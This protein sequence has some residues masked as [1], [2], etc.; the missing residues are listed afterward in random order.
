MSLLSQGTIGTL[1]C[2]IRLKL[3]T[4]VF[5]RESWLKLHLLRSRRKML[6]QWTCFGSTLIQR[7]TQFIIVN[8][9][10]QCFFPYPVQWVS[11]YNPLR[12][13][14]HQTLGNTH[15]WCLERLGG[16]RSSIFT[17]L[18]P[19]LVIS[20]LWSNE[21]NILFD[22]LVIKVINRLVIDR[23]PHEDKPTLTLVPQGNLQE[24]WL[25]LTMF[26]LSVTAKNGCSLPCLVECS[27]LLVFAFE[28]YSH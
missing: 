18:R 16:E 26:D 12:W 5:G 14:R 7:T 15:T 10:N 3:A 23:Y 1:V 9:I 20:S 4:D 22:C 11:H 21:F 25:P 27:S 2:T 24:F 19:L 28:R 13:L 8:S 6:P 17:A